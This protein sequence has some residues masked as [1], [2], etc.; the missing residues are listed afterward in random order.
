MNWATEIQGRKE[1]LLFTEF[2]IFC[3][4]FSVKK[5]ILKNNKDQKNIFLLKN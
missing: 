4:Y 1:D 2:Q 5:K 3:K